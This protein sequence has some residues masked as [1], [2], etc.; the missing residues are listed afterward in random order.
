MRAGSILL[1][2]I[3][4]IG[5]AAKMLES[6]PSR[7]F[8]ATAASALLRRVRP[9]LAWYGISIVELVLVGLLLVLPVASGASLAAAFFLLGS[10]YIAWAL[11]THPETSCGCLGATSTVRW[12][13]L[14]RSIVLAGFSLMLT[15]ASYP[16]DQTLRTTLVIVVGCAVILLSPELRPRQ[17]VQAWLSHPLPCALRPRRTKRWAIRCLESSVTW[18]QFHSYLT[19]RSPI[20]SSRRGCWRLLVYP[21]EYME[22]SVVV[23]FAIELPPARR[24][25]SLTI[26]DG[27][28]RTVSRT[29]LERPP[30]RRIR[31]TRVID[32]FTTAAIL[33]RKVATTL[34]KP[35][36]TR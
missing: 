17:L 31:Q 7:A 25:I 23:Y 15:L 19:S 16:S 34:A 12:H 32:V 29:T 24:R 22:R 4:A 1:A 35:D 26:V 18:A 20:A 36:R 9:S 30:H 21:G 28:T 11:A 13:T 3:L 10:A 5:A 6:D 2:A 8:E 27:A 33:P 14:A